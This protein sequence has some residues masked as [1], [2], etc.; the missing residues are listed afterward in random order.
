MPH[1]YMKRF[2][3]FSNSNKN[4]QHCRYAHLFGFGLFMSK[5]QEDTIM[6]LLF[7]SPLFIVM[8]ILFI[9]MLSMSFR[10]YSNN[11]RLVFLPPSPTPLHSFLRLP[12][13]MRNSLLLW[14]ERC[15]RKRNENFG[16]GNFFYDCRLSL[17]I[18][19]P[20]L[21]IWKIIFYSRL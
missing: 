15:N 21:F 2:S 9:I 10:F 11:I 19:L 7:L 4:E 6:E 8:R 13:L 17:L 12:F 16:D 1:I 14:C 18:Y 20:W 5:L 3:I